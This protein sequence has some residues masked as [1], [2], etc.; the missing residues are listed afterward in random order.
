MDNAM[1]V[2]ADKI[3][4]IRAIVDIDNEVLLKKVKQ[5]L[6]GI[7]N[8]VEE[9]SDEYI[10]KGVRESLCEYKKVKQ[11]KAKSRSVEELLDEL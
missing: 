7:L 2:E 8:I 5:Q 10:I 3:R 1:K 9:D 4:L 11:G 6:Y